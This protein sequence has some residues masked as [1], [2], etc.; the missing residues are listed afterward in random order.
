[1]ALRP[2]F[3][4]E[5]QRTGIAATVDGDGGV[6]SPCTAATAAAVGCVPGLASAPTTIPPASPTNG[7]DSDASRTTPS[8]ALPL[9]ALW[10]TADACI[11]DSTLSV[12]AAA[13][14]VPVGERGGV[15][16]DR[17]GEQSA[18]KYDPE[19]S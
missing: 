15:G 1:M 4:G 3:P 11:S 18:G 13:A 16:R 17:E 7:I 10:H 9:H 8:L 5:Q 19:K 6:I 14:S 2:S 12:K